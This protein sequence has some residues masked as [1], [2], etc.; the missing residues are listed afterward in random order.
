MDREQTEFRLSLLDAQLAAAER[1]QEV[2][3]LMLAAADMQ[4]VAELLGTS[5]AGSRMVLDT[6]WWRLT[7]EAREHLADEAERLRHE[8]RTL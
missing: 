8:L 4:A 7:K 1:A 3:A 2:T 5:E 6:Q